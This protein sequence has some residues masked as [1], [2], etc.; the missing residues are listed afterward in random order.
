MSTPEVS[1]NYELKYDTENVGQVQSVSLSID[2]NQID[3][4]TFDVAGIN[5]FIKGRSD[6][7][8]SVSCLYTRGQDDGHA[9][10]VAD[11]LAVNVAAKAFTFAPKTPVAGD[12]ILSGNARPSSV[13]IS[14]EDD[15]AVEISFDLQVS[16]TFTA[17]AHPA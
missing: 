17:V 6:V 14:A 5:A 10:L 2:S 13:E 3:V 12:L 11:S 7:S 16:E 1:Q 8:I 15:E 9:K 4:N